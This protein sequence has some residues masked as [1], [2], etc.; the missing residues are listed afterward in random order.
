MTAESDI[1][2]DGLEP[3]P[4]DSRPEVIHRGVIGGG[5]I[6]DPGLMHPDDTGA[7]GS[8]ETPTR[9]GFSRKLTWGLVVAA[10]VI[11]AAA[12]WAR[13]GGYLPQSNA[14]SPQP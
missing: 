13:D 9:S 2:P 1:E 8:I 6:S 3:R 11:A 7:P 5:A 10:L 4:R 12:T 14:A